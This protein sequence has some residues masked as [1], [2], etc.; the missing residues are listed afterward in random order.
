[1]KKMQKVCLLHLHIEDSINVEWISKIDNENKE[2]IY[3][4]D[5]SKD[6]IIR[7]PYRQIY[8]EKTKRRW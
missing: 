5:F 2:K 4:R 1:M 8:T 6:I 7:Y 3:L